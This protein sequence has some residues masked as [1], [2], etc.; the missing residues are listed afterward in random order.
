M[1]TFHLQREHDPSGVSG[2][3]IVAEGIEFSDGSCAM[4]WLVSPGGLCVYGSV[5]DLLA[6]HGHGGAS[7]VVY[8]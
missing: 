6:V 4:R 8:E 5:V 3:G 2:E 7:R 1:R